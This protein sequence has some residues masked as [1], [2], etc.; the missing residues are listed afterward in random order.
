MEKRRESWD[1][2]A[3]L[4]ILYS[5]HHRTPGLDLSMISVPMWRCALV[6]LS[7]IFTQKSKFDGGFHPPP[8]IT[9]QRFVC[10]CP[11]MDSF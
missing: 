9:F 11:P 5:L 4:V 6:Y 8:P 3:V 7:D 1:S 2:N 10:F